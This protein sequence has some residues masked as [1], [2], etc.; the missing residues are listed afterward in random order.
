MKN[1]KTRKELKKIL[2]DL[3]NEG[4]SCYSTTSGNWGYILIG[5]YFLYIQKNIHGLGWDFSLPYKPSQK[6]GTG[7][8][9]LNEVTQTIDKKFIEGCL[10]AGLNH[11]NRLG[12]TLHN[13]PDEYLNNCWDKDN[14]K[15]IK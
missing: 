6:N 9:A 7:C 14:L 8:E 4:L 12:A 2:K 5:D 15:V 3:T 10:L 11:A 13:S 1:N